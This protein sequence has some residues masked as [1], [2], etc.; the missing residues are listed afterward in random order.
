MFPSRVMVMADV[1]VGIRG[2]LERLQVARLFPQHPRA[3]GRGRDGE[4]ERG[5]ERGDGGERLASGRPLQG[6]GFSARKESD[7]EMPRASFLPSISV[8]VT[9]R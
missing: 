8:Y 7:C 6:A 1:G 4:G 3:A 9:F 5:T 2:A